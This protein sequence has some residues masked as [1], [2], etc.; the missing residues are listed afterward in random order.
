M[1]EPVRYILPRI[2]VEEKTTTWGLW[3]RHS[4]KRILAWRIVRSAHKVLLPPDAVLATFLQA[5][6]LGKLTNIE[7]R[8]H[9]PPGGT[10]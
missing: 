1:D 3:H 8:G 4:V 7:T 6:S 5:L 2:I 10:P 9:T